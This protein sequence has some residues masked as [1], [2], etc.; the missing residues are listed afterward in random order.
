MDDNKQAVAEDRKQL[1]PQEKRII[2]RVARTIQFAHSK[3][4]SGEGRKW[5]TLTADEHKLWLQLTRRAVSKIDKLRAAGPE[6][7]E[8]GDDEK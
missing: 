7:A 6:G 1:S 2:G 8:A 5:D 4:T 3:K